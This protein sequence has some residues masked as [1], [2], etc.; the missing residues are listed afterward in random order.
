MGFAPLVEAALAA[1]SG[2]LMFSRAFEE[3]VEMNGAPIIAHRA[4]EMIVAILS[5]HERR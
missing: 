5:A 1:V 2:P 3:L 4:P